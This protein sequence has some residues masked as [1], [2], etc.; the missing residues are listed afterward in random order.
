MSI[1]VDYIWYAVHKDGSLHQR[2]NPDGT[3]NIP[4]RE[5]KEFHLLPNTVSVMEGLQP[6]SLFL[7]K[8]QFL[9]YKKRRHMDQLTDDGPMENA[10]TIYI[11]GK[12]EEQNGGYFSSYCFVLPGGRVEVA[13]DFNHITWMERNLDEIPLHFYETWS[14]GLK[15]Q[16]YEILNDIL[17]RVP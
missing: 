11:L 9:I 12:E 17:V 15:Q 1:S 5:C 2:W 7:T 10:G 8:D 3:E 13:S 6:I 16:S 4:P 14:R